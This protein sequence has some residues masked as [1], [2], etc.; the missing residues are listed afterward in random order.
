[1]KLIDKR[2]LRLRATRFFSNYF[3][4]DLIDSAKCNHQTIE[5]MV[6]FYIK[7]RNE[8]EIR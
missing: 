6:E 5:M 1:M 3:G 2:Y 7:M 4:V 8:D